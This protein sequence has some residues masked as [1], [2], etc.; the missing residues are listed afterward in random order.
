MNAVARE[1]AE[2]SLSGYDSRY[3]VCFYRLFFETE[4]CPYVVA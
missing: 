2:M 1:P 3:Q 4:R